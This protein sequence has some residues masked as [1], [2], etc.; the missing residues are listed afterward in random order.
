[1][2]RA[3]PEPPEPTAS[4]HIANLFLLL[5]VV[6]LVA[7][8]FTGAKPNKTGAR[9]AGLARVTAV[10]AWGSY[11]LPAGLMVIFQLVGQSFK[12][13]IVAPASGDVLIGSLAPLMAYLSASYHGAS[14]HAALIAY[15]FWGAWDLHHATVSIF[16]HPPYAVPPAFAMLGVPDTS[17][18]QAILCVNFVVNAALIMLAA[19]TM[20]KPTVVAHF[21]GD[22][23]ND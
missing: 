16:T 15:L 11:R 21:V 8:A 7:F 5:H 6:L 22:S 2:P 14:V 23:K 3:S 9:P 19:F 18:S 10:L 1:M 20:L 13:Y 17:T 4:L 12:D